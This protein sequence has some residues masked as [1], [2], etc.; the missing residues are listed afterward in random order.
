MLNI[1]SV[2][3]CLPRFVR[4]FIIPD[5]SIPDVKND[6]SKV[7]LIRLSHVYF[8]HPNLKEFTKFALDFGFVE[9]HRDNDTI[10]F[11]GYGKDPYCYVAMES[12]D[13]KPH[14]GGGAF[15]AASREEF[16]KAKNIEGALVKS[17][18]APGGGEM[19]TFAR[20][21]D[22]FMHVVFGQEERAVET[23]H[24]PTATHENLGA[25]NTPF[26][27]PRQGQ[28]QRFHEGPA[29]VHK[30]GHFGYVCRDFDSELEFYTSNFNFVHSD[31]LFHPKFSNIDVLTFMH[32]DLGKEYSDHHTLFLQRAPPEVKKTYVHHSS[33]EVADFDTQLIG[34][35]WLGKKGWKS[36][37]G[38]GR[39]ILGS[40]IFDYWMDPSGFK[41]E[42]YADGDIVNDEKEA[43][44][45]V[46]GAISIW[47]PELPKDFGE[48]STLV[49]F[50]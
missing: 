44:K 16:E 24:V 32:L 38:V 5:M 25:F 3:S 48:D 22:T 11:R 49:A 21:G 46:A 17:L 29:L 28:F 35:E 23:E 18:N 31:I 1:L 50:S 45:E 12:K 42:H 37:W 4:E 33:F 20:P 47:G 27:K 19:V 36:V 10:Y 41:I 39:H 40:Q 15:V 8:S 14:F 34:H 6:P 13:G 2:L 43:R 7:Q 30:L 26:E 9:A